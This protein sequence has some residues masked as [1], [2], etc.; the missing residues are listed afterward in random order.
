VT[1]P[2]PDENLSD[3]FGSAARSLRRRTRAALEPLGITPSLSRALSV[4]A[5]GSPVRISTL[6][7]H[8]RVA[9]RTATE[10]VDDLESRGLAARRPDPADRRAVLVEL[11]P[12]GERAAGDMRAAREAEAERFFG[13]LSGADRRDLA[14]ILR[15]L[16]D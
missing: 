14:R 5:H 9:A 12:A 6:A 11:T 10:L 2:E 8:L 4:L 15:S 13:T 1:A 7:E 16:R 3:L